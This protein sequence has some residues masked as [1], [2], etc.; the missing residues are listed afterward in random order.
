M[1]L[2]DRPRQSGSSTPLPPAPTPGQKSGDPTTPVPGAPNVRGQAGAWAPR[3]PF[4]WPEWGQKPTNR[5]LRAASF[6]ARQA[7]VPRRG[8]EKGCRQVGTPRKGGA[9]IGRQVK[10]RP[11]RWRSCGRRGRFPAALRRC[12]RLFLSPRS[13]KWRQRRLKGQ[14]GK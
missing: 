10:S 2:T 6:G 7:Q 4:S 12:P 1:L 13:Q 11:P 9:C 14:M 3:L 8:G 5:A